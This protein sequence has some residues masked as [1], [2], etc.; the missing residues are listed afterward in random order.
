MTLQ[1]YVTLA[2]L[3][4]RRAYSEGTGVQEVAVSPG[5][6]IALALGLLALTIV[7]GLLLQRRRARVTNLA[8]SDALDARNFALAA[9][10]PRATVVQFSTVYCQRCPGVRRSIA[11]LVST[12][13]GTA[14]AH[15]DVTND[16]ALAAKY[17]LKQTPTILLIDADGRA[18]TRLAGPVTAPEI[19]QALT[20][21]L[22][23]AA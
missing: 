9:F 17:N 6:A 20:Q 11:Q 22:E 2:R 7:L 5:S 21:L 18:R 1:C 16:P 15:V 10:A 19:D 23:G 12:R 13:P 14:F 4:S 3:G 8:T